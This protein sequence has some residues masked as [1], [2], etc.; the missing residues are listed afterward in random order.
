MKWAWLEWL[1]NGQLSAH[2][3]RKHLITIRDNKNSVFRTSHTE[4]LLTGRLARHG[5]LSVIVWVSATLTLRG[6]ACPWWVC[7]DIHDHLT[8]WFCHQ[9]RP[10]FTHSPRHFWP[11]SRTSWEM[12]NRWQTRGCMLQCTDVVD[13]DGG[14]IPALWFS[15]VLRVFEL[16][17]EASASTTNLAKWSVPLWFCEPRHARAPR[18]KPSPKVTGGK[19]RHNGFSRIKN[20]KCRN[21]SHARTP[22]KNPS[23][24]LGL[25]TSAFAHVPTN[26]HQ[27]WSDL[28]VFRVSCCYVFRTCLAQTAALPEISLLPIQDVSRNII[29][30]CTPTQ[31]TRIQHS[32][33]NACCLTSIV[34]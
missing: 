2:R 22:R 8:L 13:E 9:D 28:S 30:I 21:P 1:C 4:R 18:K 20:N 29:T 11:Q 33:Y 23:P 25:V 14:D 7:Q 15:M 31:K 27:I 5:V 17:Q 3:L 19:I 34:T 6:T 26:Q 12:Q 32:F 24:L 16:L 10:W